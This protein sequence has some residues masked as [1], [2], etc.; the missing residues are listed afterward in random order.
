MISAEL[1]AVDAGEVAVENDDVVGVEVD[2]RGGFEAVV[3]DVDGHALV[4]QSFGDPVGVAG[5][6]LDDEDPHLIVAASCGT[7]A[8]E[9]DLD[10]EPAFWAG[11]EL[12]AAAVRGGDGGDDREPEPVAVLRAGPVLRRGV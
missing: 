11:L 1:V 2:L 4:A 7:A 5:H 8:G 9:G 6:V 3:G 12:E 10:A